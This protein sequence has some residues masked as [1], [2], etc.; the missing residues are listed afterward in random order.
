MNEATRRYVR[1][2]ADDDVRMLALRGCKDPD[3]DLS[4]A[5]QQ[6]QG[7]Q[8]AR[9]KLP[10]WAALDGLCYPPHLNM[11]QCSSEQTARYKA[12]LCRRVTG[13]TATS[14]VDLTGGL[15]VDFAFMSQAFSQSTYVERNGSLLAIARHNFGVL[16]VE[17]DCV[18]ADGT[19]YFRTLGHVTMAFLDPARRDDAGQRTYGIADCTPDV[20][21]IKDELLGVADWVLLKLSPMLDWRKT[22]ADLGPSFVREVH[23]V[24][25]GGECKE[26][27]VLLSREGGGL[28]LY[29]ANDDQLFVV[30][31]TDGQTMPVESAQPR[32][33]DYL[34]EPNAAIMKAG[35]FDELCIAFGLRPVARN[36]H[37]FL[38]SQPI[39]DFPGRQFRVRAVTSMNKRDLRQTLS[40]MELANITVRN[41]PLTVAELRKRLRLADGGPN[42]LFATTFH[43]GT[44]A[45]LLCDKI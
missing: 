20:L 45:L 26:L 11:E 24:A 25:A 18:E 34:Y 33:G 19:D 28:H 12:D 22:V 43:D 40:G 30:D 6:I 3:V 42:Y 29:C 5:L 23:V 17:A 44:H 15:G 27:L 37:L 2:H 36:S 4:L 31:E 7:R 32:P 13:G 41:F 35:C 14:L 21:A 38:S 16:G 10:S 1:Q 9:R 39:A 8:T